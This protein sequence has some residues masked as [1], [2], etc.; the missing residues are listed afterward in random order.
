METEFCAFTCRFAG[1]VS[2]YSFLL[3]IA[4]KGVL[5]KGYW[6]LILGNLFCLSG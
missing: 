2:Y 3:K 6:L 5:V 1:A 4:V